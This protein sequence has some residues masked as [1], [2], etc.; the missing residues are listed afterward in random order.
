MK[1][2][3]SE[4]KLLDN[5]IGTTES[6]YI[7]QIGKMV[8]D[9]SYQTIPYYVTNERY[10]IRTKDRCMASHIHVITQDGVFLC[11]T[12]LEKKNNTHP[13]V[14]KMQYKADMLASV[15]YFDEHGYG[16]YSEPPQFTTLPKVSRIALIA[17][18]ADKFCGE[19]KEV[20]TFDGWK[21][22]FVIPNG[23][24]IQDYMA[25]INE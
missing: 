4:K 15:L 1:H 10:P 11:T 7:S 9:W 22:E 6:G 24:T 16:Y 5:I 17:G 14:L 21:E 25:L 23:I 19:Q 20:Y 8:Y 3:I 13:E 18:W 12:F 2:Y